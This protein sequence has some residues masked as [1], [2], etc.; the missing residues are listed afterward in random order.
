MAF[1]VIKTNKTIAELQS[2][3]TGQIHLIFDA[4]LIFYDRQAGTYYKLKKLKNID[5][6]KFEIDFDDSSCVEFLS[7]D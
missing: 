2:D 4:E 3:S 5:G 1:K 7:E 6:S